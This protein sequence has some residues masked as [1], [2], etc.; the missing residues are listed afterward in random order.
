MSSEEYVGK[1]EFA[2]AMNQIAA[3]F[4]MVEELA[5]ELGY[6]WSQDAGCWVEKTMLD[7]FRDKVKKQKHD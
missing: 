5:R 7:Q 3:Q 1:A 2:T 4:K 6:E